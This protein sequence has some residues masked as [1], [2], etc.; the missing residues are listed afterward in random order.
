MWTDG[1]DDGGRETGAVERTDAQS[2]FTRPNAS[3]E[4]AAPPEIAWM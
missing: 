3:L 1:A 4:V 2:D